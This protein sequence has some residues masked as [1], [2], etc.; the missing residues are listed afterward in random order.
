MKKYIKPALCGIAIGVL[1]GMFGAGGGVM[2]VLFLEKLMNVETHKAHAA[3]VAV[4]LAVT[5][6]SLFFYIKNG[7]YDFGM[8]VQAACGGILGGIIG[9]KILSKINDKW[10]HGIFGGFM[11][12]AGIKLLMG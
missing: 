1:N 11:I 2:A 12:L 7:V 3:A 8:T 10:L 4:I 9:A 5:P 6:I